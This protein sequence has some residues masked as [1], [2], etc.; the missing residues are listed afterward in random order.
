MITSILTSVKKTLGLPEADTSFDEDIILFVNSVFAT[1]NQLGV[2]P[3]DG[4]AIEDK[5]PTWDAFLGTDKR[6]NNVKQYVQMRVRMAFDPPSTSYHQTAMENQI[7]ELEWRI[8]AY[9]EETDWINPDPGVVL[10]DD[11]IVDGGNP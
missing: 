5:V 8:N 9:R 10:D 11:I 4:F 1:L 3:A 7:K 2:G 6:K